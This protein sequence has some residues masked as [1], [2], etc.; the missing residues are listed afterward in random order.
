MPAP[1][2]LTSVGVGISKA[3]ENASVP[4]TPLYTA[5]TCGSG[6]E[7]GPSDRGQGATPPAAASHPPSSSL[8]FSGSRMFASGCTGLMLVPPEQHSAV[9]CSGGGLPTSVVAAMSMAMLGH[10]LFSALELQVQCTARGESNTY[11]M[12]S[13]GAS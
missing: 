13:P 8:V 3:P 4:T 5:E 2:P 7:G 12:Y 9:N 1:V 11:C 6:G 10:D